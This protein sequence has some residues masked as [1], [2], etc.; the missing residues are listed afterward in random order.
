MINGFSILRL[1]TSV[2]INT[3]PKID[4]FNKILVCDHNRIY[5]ALQ[6]YNR[7]VIGKNV[8]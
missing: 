8:P 3:D 4:P 2:Y 6:S 5:T 1:T 7:K